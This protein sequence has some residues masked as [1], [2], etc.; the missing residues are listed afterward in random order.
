MTMM[1]FGI[2]VPV[3][4]TGMLTVI[5]TIA[6]GYFFWKKERAERSVARADKLNQILQKLEEGEVATT[7][8]SLVEQG[9]PFFANG[10][11]VD[12]EAERSVDKMLNCL[13]Y[14]CY[15]RRRRVIARAEFEEFAYWIARTISNDQVIDYLECLY[16]KY[17]LEVDER[18][19]V[20]LIRYGRWI[21]IDRVDELWSNFM[22]N[23][24]WWERI[25]D[26]LLRIIWG[27]WCEFRNIGRSRKDDV[28]GERDDSV[29]TEDLQDFRAFLKRNY[30][31]KSASSIFTCAMGVAG[32]LGKPLS[33]L[34]STMAQLDISLRQLNQQGQERWADLSNYRHALKTFFNFKNGIERGCSSFRKGRGYDKCG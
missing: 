17:R 33:K 21:G 3:T 4:A 18:P 9:K 19:F 26:W 20:E 13:S 15:L 5:T 12:E 10:E 23:R 14:L 24:P 7:F 32:L 29:A 30:S 34:A 11:F 8:Y 22:A 27:M 16:E 25:A 6:S 28:L 31:A 2:D 1:V